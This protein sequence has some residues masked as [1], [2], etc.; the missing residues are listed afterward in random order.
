MQAV[1]WRRKRRNSAAGGEFQKDVLRQSK[2]VRVQVKNDIERGA[3]RLDL[4]LA[5]KV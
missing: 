1:E 5:N 4:R 3:Q 2:V